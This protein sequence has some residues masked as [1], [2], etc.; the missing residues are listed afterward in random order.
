MGFLL[1]IFGKQNGLQQNAEMQKSVLRNGFVSGWIVAARLA[2][3][4]ALATF[5]TLVCR[6][7][8]A[9]PDTCKLQ[10]TERNGRQAP[11]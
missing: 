9:T 5:A 4:A 1:Q 6:L 2:A 3:L 10:V 8:G 11:V 7:A